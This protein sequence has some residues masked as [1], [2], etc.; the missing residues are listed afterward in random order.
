[1]AATPDRGGYWL[2]GT[3]GRVDRFG[4]AVHYGDLA[5]QTL[6]KPIAAIAAK[7]NGGGYWLLDRDGRVYAFGS[8]AHHGN[9]SNQDLE[10]IDQILGPLNWTTV[11]VPAS[12]TAAHLLSTPSGAGYGVFLQNGTVCRFGDA[13]RLGNIYRT[14]INGFLVLLKEPYYPASSPCN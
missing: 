2:V 7:A 12:T 1:M 5:G 14:T 13:P 8:A 6:P 9:A 3:D 11:P 4:T 10:R